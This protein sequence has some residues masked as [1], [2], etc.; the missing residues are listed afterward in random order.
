MARRSGLFKAL[1]GA[2]RRGAYDSADEAEAMARRRRD[3][4]KRA[5]PEE[6]LLAVAAALET[7]EDDN[8]PGEDQR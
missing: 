3:D 8:V 1:E 7:L 4:L 2:L 5:R 6:D